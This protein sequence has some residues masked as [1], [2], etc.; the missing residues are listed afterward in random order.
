MKGSVFFNGSHCQ[1]ASRFDDASGVNED[2]FDGCTD[3]IR[4]HRHV[5]VHQVLTHTKGLLAHEFDSRA[6]REKPH[7]VQTHSLSSLDGLNHG[8]GVV[9]LYANDLHLWPDCFDVIGYSRNEPAPAYG[10]K[11]RIQGTRALTQYLHGNG[12][13]SRD[14]IRVVKGVDKGEAFLLF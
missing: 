1:S 4:V 2:V 6:V 12:A 7:I 9:H 11:D 5:L 8:V 14:H 3:L 10:H 13:L